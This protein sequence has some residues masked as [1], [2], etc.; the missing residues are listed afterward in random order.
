MAIIPEVNG[1]SAGN[2]TP[3]SAGVQLDIFSNLKIEKGL[4]KHFIENYP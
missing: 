4:D 2:Y 1:V 3:F